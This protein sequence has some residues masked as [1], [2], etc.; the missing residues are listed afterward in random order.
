MKP[1][2]EKNGA[3]V[4]SYEDAPKLQNEEIAAVRTGEVVD[5]GDRELNP[6]G[7]VAR[8][9]ATVLAVNPDRRLMNRY[10]VVTKKGSGKLMQVVT[11]YRAVREQESGHCYL[12]QLPAYELER[13]EEGKLK[14]AGQTTIT[15]E[16]FI[17][18]FTKSLSNEAM[19]EVNK[20]I[21]ARE[22]EL[23]KDELPI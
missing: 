3:K 10:R 20:A 15:R 6:D 21:A 22:D 1:I 12:A 17:A 18:K 11:D 7:T 23:E 19:Y 2:T 5:L 14:L 13:D 16:D 8:S 4:V 9:R